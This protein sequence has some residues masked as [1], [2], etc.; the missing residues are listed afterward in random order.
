MATRATASFKIEAWDETVISEGDGAPRLARVSVKK[1]FE[2]DLAGESTAE[3][4]M[5]QAS[6]EVAG[7]VG[8]ERV[9]GTLAGRRGTF[10]VQHCAAKGGTNDR[11]LWFV[12]P[13]SGTGELRGLSGEVTYR[14]DETGAVFTLDYELPD[15]A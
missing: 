9:T 1:R 12:A 5:S 2:G 15:P 11:A 10:D 14:H 4:L 7:Y 3:L 13:G 6:P 8:M